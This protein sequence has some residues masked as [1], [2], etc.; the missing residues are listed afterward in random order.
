MSKGSRE[1]FL[2]LNFFKGKRSCIVSGDNKTHSNV[3][4]SV[5]NCSAIFLIRRKITVLSTIS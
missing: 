5:G 2:A 3:P 4:N 1:F